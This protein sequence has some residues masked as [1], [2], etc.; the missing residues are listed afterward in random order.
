MY[1]KLNVDG[2]NK[3][4]SAQKFVAEPSE[5]KHLHINV[6]MICG[7]LDAGCSL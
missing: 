3:V 4:Q 5:Q 6:L 1:G 7:S 2:G